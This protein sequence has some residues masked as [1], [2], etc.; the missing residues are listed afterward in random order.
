MIWKVRFGRGGSGNVMGGLVCGVVLKVCLLGGEG[1][2][3]GFCVFLGCGRWG[4]GFNVKGA[5]LGRYRVCMD[6]HSGIVK[7]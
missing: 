6:E 4:C 7:G 2:G 1:L 5:W 3:L